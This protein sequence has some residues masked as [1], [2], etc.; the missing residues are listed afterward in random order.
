[1][2]DNG[3]AL[4]VFAG[5]AHEELAREICS[6]LGCKLGDAEIARFSDGEIAVKINESV[7]G[8]DTFVVQPT[9]PPC[10][11][12]LMEL[13]VMIDSLRRASA[14]RIT[15]VIPYYGYAR[16]DR[17]AAARDPITAKLIANLITTA[18]VGRVLT[19]DLHAPQIQGFFDIPVDHLYGAPILAKYFN[20][21]RLA[22]L[23]VVAPDVGAVR[24]SR[25]FAQRLE[26]SL[27]IIDKRRPKP[28]V[29]EVMNVIGEVAGRNLILFDDMIDTAGTITHAAKVL[30]GMG[31][32]SIFA[33]CTH[34][35]FSGP[36]V[37]RLSSAPIDE[38][39]VLNTIPQDIKRLPKMRI[40]SVASLIAEAIERIHLHQSV[41][42]LF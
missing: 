11:E 33:C 5:N 20:D 6:H 28:N 38:L 8:A 21:K 24:D 34:P 4:K 30:K 14:N 39:V 22:D 40:L 29:S 10:N 1:M 35:I 25:S 31:A 37:E 19:I 7:R 41:S 18:G 23:T 2:Q 3:N 9:C 27:A 12:N 13:L 42:V 26:A 17:K 36:A 15:A 16:Q 32:Q